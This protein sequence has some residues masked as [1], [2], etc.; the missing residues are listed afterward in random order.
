VIEFYMKKVD[1]A[2]IRE[3]LR[4]TPGQRLDLLI[5]EQA[6][7]AAKRSARIREEPGKTA[8]ARTS[9]NEMPAP[10]PFAGFPT[11]TPEPDPAQRPM[12]FPDPVIE[13]YMKDVDRG[14]IRE[15]LKKTP[16]ERLQS[17]I[18]MAEYSEELHRAGE[19]LRSAKPRR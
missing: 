7:E 19:K 4:M 16:S 1:R 3:R 14:L 12:L 17:L 15:Q 13:V 8:Q 10:K 11:Y 2:A 18:A 6:A 5:K 9:P